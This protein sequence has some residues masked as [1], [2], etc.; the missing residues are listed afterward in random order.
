ME[1]RL[2]ET[3]QKMIEDVV[4]GMRT[5]T[6]FIDETSFKPPVNC[7]MDV[8]KINPPSYSENVKDM[9]HWMNGIPKC[10]E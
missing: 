4:N 10:D 1:N 8:Q 6:F 5:H 2:N 3:E 9:I 7:T